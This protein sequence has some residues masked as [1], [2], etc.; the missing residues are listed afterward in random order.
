[1]SLAPVVLVRGSGSMGLRHL[2]IVRDVLRLETVAVPT[3]SDRI[4]SLNALG[5]EAHASVAAAVQERSRVWSIVA[6]D[7]AR[8]V[9]DAIE[10][11]P[12]GDVLIEKPLA[13]SAEGIGALA[14]AAARHG[15]RTFTAFCLRFTPL[16]QH[17]QSIVPE[18]GAI[19]SVRIEAQSYLPDWRPARDYRRTY[20]ARRGEGGVLRDLSHE[21]DYVTWLFG[22]PA[23]VFCRIGNGGT[24]GIESDEAAD[25]LWTI[26]GGPIVSMRLDYVT[27]VPRRRMAI[28]AEEGSLD[29]DLITGTVVH[30]AVD[31]TTTR[32]ALSTD[33][34][35]MV[36]AQAR[37][38]IHGVCAE[39][40]AT[41]D[42]AAFVVA[43]TDA[44]HESAVEDRPVRIR[45]DF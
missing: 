16:L 6:T 38:F 13:P 45:G 26:P 14:A 3:R 42:E 36:A 8:H 33:R 25:L 22:R 1:M 11:L 29:C 18:M 44:A 4:A 12:H 34:D 7:T 41:F 17:V 39:H 21:V 27:R 37:A 35:A 24:L 30:S 20:S 32:T 40:L 5:F 10:L 2:H 28:D 9:N 23:E 31:G 43:L 19:H 15:R